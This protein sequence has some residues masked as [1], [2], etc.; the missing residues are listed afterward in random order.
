MKYPLELELRQYR[1]SVVDGL[2]SSTRQQAQ[3]LSRQDDGIT[4]LIGGFNFVGSGLASVESSLDVIGADLARLVTTVDSSLPSIVEYL[5]VST[6]EITDISHMMA[7]PEETRGAECFRN[8]TR[9]LVKAQQAGSPARTQ[10]W[11]D[12]AVRELRKA[13]E[14]HEDHP[15]A[16]FNLGITLGRL[17]YNEE[18]ADAFASS[19]FFGIDESLAFGATAVLLAAGLFRRADLSDKS[20]EILHEYLGQ[21]D[22]CAEIHLALAVHHRESNQLTKALAIYPY[23]AADAKAAKAPNAES[24]IAGFCDRDDSE[25]AYLT[26]L[27]RA[28]RELADSAIALELPGVSPIPD[29]AHLASNGVGSLLTALKATPRAQAT[30]TQLHRE[31]SVFVRSLQVAADQARARLERA[32]QAGAELIKQVQRDSEA[33]IA[34]ARASGAEEIRRAEHAGAVRIE[35]AQSVL[36]SKRIAIDRDIASKRVAMDR[37]VRSRRKAI[38]RAIQDAASVPDHLRDLEQKTTAE[39]EK[40]WQLTLDRKMVEYGDRR[41]GRAWSREV[42]SI[43]ESINGI[44]LR[45]RKYNNEVDGIMLRSKSPW[46]RPA[47]TKIRLEEQIRRSQL[48]MSQLNKDILQL[49]ALIQPGPPNPNFPPPPWPDWH[50][51]A[52]SELLAV[53]QDLARAQAEADETALAIESWDPKNGPELWQELLQE[54]T[55]EQERAATSLQHA[56]AQADQG[57][58]LATIQAETVV[59]SDEAGAET[60]IKR[61][62]ANDEATVKGAEADAKNALQ[63]A[64]ADAAEILSLAVRSDD[65]A[66]THVLRVRGTVSDQLAKL[67]EALVL[68]RPPVERIIPFDLR[69]F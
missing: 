53:Q 9:A 23:L 2:S 65:A 63:A 15:K 27:Q 24:V 35:R 49:E 56:E 17:S 11:Y 14:I 30:A 42:G 10:Q 64:K 38:A 41:H 5:A 3:M 48:R 26:R 20:A 58:R 8:G 32:P 31:V 29:Q 68:I 61:A 50:E 19:A 6:K 44:E 55:A 59:T 43:I 22:R 39:L 21:L 62:E 69:G 47:V 66:Q 1:Q 46:L 33:R 36:A 34:Q 52:K 40:V 12:R 45:I 7:T 37:G 25:T 51:W 16:W 13:V 67:E 18:A 60:G 28:I 57:L 4:T 54:W